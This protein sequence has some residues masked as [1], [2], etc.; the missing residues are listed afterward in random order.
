MALTVQNDSGGINNANG[1]VT[2]VEFKAYHDDRGNDYSGNSDTVISKAIVR[3]TDYLD[4]RFKF[5]GERGRVEQRTSWPRIDAEDSDGICRFGI[6]SEVKEATAEYALRALDG[7][8]A[9]DPARDATGQVV[10]S[11]SESVGPISESVSYGAGGAFVMP[12]YP[13][14]DR[15][16]TVPGLTVSGRDLRR[17]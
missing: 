12:A 7:A 3:A 17:A 16:L 4:K 8:L 10:T 1:Y 5:V 11:K 14:A 2:V 6:P 13:A 9:P 15:L